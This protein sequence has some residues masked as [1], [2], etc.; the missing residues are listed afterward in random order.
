VGI[1]RRRRIGICR[2]EGLDCLDDALE[3][4][5]GFAQRVAVGGVE[6]D[7][8]GGQSADAAFAAFEQQRLSGSGSGEHGTARVAGVGGAVDQAEF[9]E[10]LHD[11][12]HRGGP[13]LFC[14]SQIF[15]GDRA[16][17][18]DHRQR[19]EARRAQTAVRVF[20]AQLAQKVDGERVDVFRDTLAG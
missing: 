8:L 1:G 4:F 13:N 5:S 2:G 3:D 18:D 6:R 12:G 11:A 19:G 10:G 20:A 9:F 14:G 15:E 17:K 16:G 7:D